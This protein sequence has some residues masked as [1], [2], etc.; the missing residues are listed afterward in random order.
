MLDGAPDCKNAVSK[1]ETAFFVYPLRRH[2]QLPFVEQGPAGCAATAEKPCLRK[3]YRASAS[4]PFTNRS[5]L[6]REGSR[7]YIGMVATKKGPPGTGR[8]FFSSSSAT[9]HTLAR[10]AAGATILL[11]SLQPKAAWNSGMFISGPLVRNWAGECGSTCT[12][13]RRNSGRALVRQIWA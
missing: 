7:C 9:Y 13:W 1:L 5:T 4:A 3:R 8:A 11:P 6:R 10:S 2:R 12:C